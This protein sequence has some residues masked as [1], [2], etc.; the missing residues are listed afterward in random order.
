MLPLAGKEETVL[1]ML[2]NG[3]VGMVSGVANVVPGAVSAMYTA[4]AAGNR[5]E[6]RA[7]FYQK[8]NPIV[9]MTFP[10]R[11][12][13]IQCVKQCLAWKGIIASP[14]TRHPL[15]ALDAVRVE[16]LRAAAEIAGV[17]FKG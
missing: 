4:Y 14:A 11:N 13:F 9:T 12:E 8:I 6:A 2:G 1:A 7:V 16:E 10:A 15:P 5:D 3:A 17:Q